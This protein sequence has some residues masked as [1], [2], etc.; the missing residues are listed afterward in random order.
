MKKCKKCEQHKP[1]SEFNKAES[2][3][4]NRVNYCRD[5]G[6]KMRK[7]TADRIKEGTIQ[8]Y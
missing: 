6:K 7:A 3:G 2:H 1:L 5:C 8:A 4:Q